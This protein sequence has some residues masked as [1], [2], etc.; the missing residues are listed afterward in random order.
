MNEIT[1]RPYQWEA[2]RH[3]TRL[4][5]MMNKPDFTVEGLEQACR[6]FHAENG[7]H[8]K[9]SS[10]DAS[11]YFGWPKG[12][13]TWVNVYACIREGRRGL[14]DL[15][16]SSLSKM[17][18][19]WGLKKPDFT[20]ESVEKACR[21]FYSLHGTYPKEKGGD[22]SPYFGGPKG[23]DTW[24]N[25]D[26][27]IRNGSRGLESL[28]GSSLSKMCKVW[29]LKKPDFTPESVEKACRT[30]HAQHGTH[31]YK[32][33]G[34]CSLYFDWPAGTETWV[35]VDAC[36]RNGSRG[37]ESLK[38]SSLAKMCKVW[39]LKKPD[40]PLELLEP[41]CHAFRA[42]HG[43]PPNKNS[44]DCSKYFGWPEGTETWKNVNNCIRDGRRGLE[45]LRGSTIAKMCR[46]WGLVFVKPDFT[47][48]S[49]E[50]VCRAYHTEHGTHPKHK[51]GDC[52][53]YFDWPDGTETWSNV[54][55]CIR[56]GSR[57]LESLKGSSLSKMCK[58]WGLKK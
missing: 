36:I 52:S 56:N 17:C 44:G 6:K 31:P 2:T 27:C 5:G 8:P 55:Q 29:G 34:D 12:T 39:G 57:G 16:G 40:F 49:V 9:Q 47:P 58:V 15:K 20:P 38:G 26:T 33:S 41:A 4:K 13:D 51:S 43:A 22:A 25:V 32:N 23:T 37:L 18:K 45:S 46:V 14:E 35:N 21:E 54:D 10:G 50:R 3:A 53:P 1:L 11:P 24:D 7:T 28:K 42:E 19:V 30:Y 48:E